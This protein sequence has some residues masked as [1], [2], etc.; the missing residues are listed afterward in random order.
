MNY[1]EI[2]FN[3]KKFN[4]RMDMDSKEK[5]SYSTKLLGLQV[6]TEGQHYK[7]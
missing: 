2:F 6:K 3:V 4:I 5:Q 1:K 7:H